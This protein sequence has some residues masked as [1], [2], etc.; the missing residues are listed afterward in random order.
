MSQPTERERTAFRLELARDG[1]A[2]V[3]RKN[4]VDH[5]YGDPRHHWR[6]REALLFLKEQERKDE[7]AHRE[8]VLEATRKANEIS[9]DANT[10]AKLAAAGA[11]GAFVVAALAFAKS[12]G[13]F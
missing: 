7:R 12:M 5:I 9:Q 10:I 13:W 3:R 8:E 2:E 4:E 1:V 6:A 11:F